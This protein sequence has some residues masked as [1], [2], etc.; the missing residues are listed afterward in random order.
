[1]DALAGYRPD[2][3]EGEIV[4]Y[5]ARW[6]LGRSPMLIR[7]WKWFTGARLRL[8]TA[9]GDHHTFIRPPHVAELARRLKSALP[10]VGESGAR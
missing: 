9:P 10:K 4:F 3:Y 1:M 7:Q 6:S 8:E 5:Q 2:R